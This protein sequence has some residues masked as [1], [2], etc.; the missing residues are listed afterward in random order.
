MTTQDLNRS[1]RIEVEEYRIPLYIRTFLVLLI[2][3]LPIA[4][5]YYLIGLVYIAANP[6]ASVFGFSENWIFIGM[7]A[8]LFWF[9]YI[10][11]S[12][13]LSVLITGVMGRFEARILKRFSP[14]IIAMWFGIGRGKKFTAE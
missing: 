5:G 11:R 3:T 8:Y 10:S 7:S 2:V 14:E 1:L 13:I 6:G 12:L 4:V 9:L